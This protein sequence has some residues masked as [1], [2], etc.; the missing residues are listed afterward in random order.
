MKA[1]P[2]SSACLHTLF[3]FRGEGIDPSYPATLIPLVAVPVLSLLMPDAEDDELSE[4]FYSR[5][6]R[7]DA[8]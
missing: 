1:P 4:T 2:A 3:V 8:A 6:S 5:L 7:P